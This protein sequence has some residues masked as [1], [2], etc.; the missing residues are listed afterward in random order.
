MT[1][2]RSKWIIK[3]RKPHSWQGTKIRRLQCVIKLF[4]NL[5]RGL[6][7]FNH[8][9][10]IFYD[11]LNF[12]WILYFFLHNT[13]NVIHSTKAKAKA[14]GSLQWSLMINK[15]IIIDDK[16]ESMDWDNN[17]VDGHHDLPH[18]LSIFSSH[19]FIIFKRLRKFRNYEKLSSCVRLSL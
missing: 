10:I 7:Q 6:K 18:M 11:K 5:R 9:M 12:M 1:L 14:G 3:M 15:A 2:K 8:V 17:L 4:N 16:R 19:H 13:F